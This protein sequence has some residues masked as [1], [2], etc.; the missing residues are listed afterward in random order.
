MIVVVGGVAAG[1][2]P[3][4]KGTQ[5]KQNIELK[6]LSAGTQGDQLFSIGLI[7]DASL[8]ERR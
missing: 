5:I 6:G 4:N 3:S 2:E 1:S 7:Y 8:G